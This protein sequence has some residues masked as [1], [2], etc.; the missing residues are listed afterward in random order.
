MDPMCTVNHLQFLAGC[1]A[2][3]AH[4][5]LCRRARDACFSQTFADP[6]CAHNHKWSYLVIIPYKRS[7]WAHLPR[8]LLNQKKNMILLMYKFFLGIR[9][10][11]AYKFLWSL[12]YIYIH[13][14]HTNHIMI[15]LP[16]Q[17]LQGYPTANHLGHRCLGK[18]NLGYK[19]KTIGHQRYDLKSPCLEMAGA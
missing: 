12:K 8:N 3:L 19:A 9:N 15:P 17:L 2:S 6:G 1:P 11:E 13:T 18:P 7:Y 4:A 5:R 10:L 16:S 14:W